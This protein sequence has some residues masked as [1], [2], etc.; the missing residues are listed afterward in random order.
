MGLGIVG[1][2]YQALATRTGR[3]PIDERRRAA[4]ERRAASSSTCDV[5]LRCTDGRSAS[6]NSGGA[7]RY[8]GPPARSGNPQ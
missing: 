7:A 5:T 4:A 2:P 3:E 8:G 6:A 1:P